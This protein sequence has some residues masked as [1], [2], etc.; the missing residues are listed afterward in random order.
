MNIAFMFPGQGAQ[1]VGMGKE[2]FDKFSFV[3]EIYD[4]A[5]KILGYD[6]CDLSFNGPAEKLGRT[7]YSQ[8]AILVASVACFKVLQKKVPECGFSVGGGLSL[9]EY[10]ALVATGA[11]SFQDAVELVSH[12]A[13]FMEEASQ[14]CKGGMA[15]IL[16]LEE[17]VV[18]NIL[19]EEGNSIDVAN[20]NSPGQV[21]I[22]GEVEDINNVLPTLKE[23]GARRA[24]LLNVSGPF[25]SRKMETARQKLTPYIEKVNIQKPQIPFV[26]NVTGALIDDP[27]EIKKCLIEQVSQSTYWAKSIQTM[28][29]MGAE[30]FIEIGPGK[31]LGGLLKRIDKGLSYHN[32]EN[33]ESLARTKEDIG[34]AARK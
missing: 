7:K 29:A 8:P 32:I 24:M 18:R 19:K 21:V 9:G 3:K 5:N 13:Q 28:A 27:L 22:S 6:L 2:F 4:I 25:H 31:V 16:G 14:E 30:K 1:Y 15:S 34:Y 11:I 17:D 23:A 12:R 10:T 33:N 26:A 20:L